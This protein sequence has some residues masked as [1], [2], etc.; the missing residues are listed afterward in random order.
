MSCKDYLKSSYPTLVLS[1]QS[2][3][4]EMPVPPLSTS[5]P[6]VVHVSQMDHMDPVR[7]Q[8]SEKTWDSEPCET[9]GRKMTAA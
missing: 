3:K 8:F 4:Q 5:L 2:L 6:S 1:N 9:L 7:Y